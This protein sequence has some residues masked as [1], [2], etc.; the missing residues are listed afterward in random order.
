MEAYSGDGCAALTQQLKAEKDNLAA[1]SKQQNEAAN[2][3]AFGVFLIGVPMS[4]LTGGDKEGE[5]SNAKGK[6]NAMEAAMH[7]NK[8]SGY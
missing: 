6:I 3:D 7:K 8:C 5:I 1:L 4:S 2:G